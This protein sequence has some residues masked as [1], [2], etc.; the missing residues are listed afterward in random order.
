MGLPQMQAR[1][2]R[3]H[4][5]GLPGQQARNDL[6]AVA[7][8]VV[9]LLQE[10]LLVL[11]QRLGL[12]ERLRLFSDRRPFLAVAETKWWVPPCRGS[13]RRGSSPPGAVEKNGQGGLD[14][15]GAAGSEGNDPCTGSL[16]R[17]GGADCIGL[18]TD[19]RWSAHRSMCG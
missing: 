17:S 3:L 13:S 14:R 16:C 6:Q 4:L 15:T 1:F 12:C 8:S 2:F 5:P 19:R 9:H 10:G 18:L 7:H 11:E